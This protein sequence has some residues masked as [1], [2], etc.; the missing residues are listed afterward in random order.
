MPGE[1]GSTGYT[2]PIG[3][4]GPGGGGS[5]ITG[6]GIGNVVVYDTTSQTS[7][8]SEVVQIDNNAVLPTQDN[9]YSLGNTG[10]RWKEI[11]MGP[12]T[13]FIAGPS[14][15]TGATLGANNQ[16]IAY[17]ESGF[18]TPFINIGPA[19]LTPQASG[20]WELYAQGSATGPNYTLVAQQ[21]DAITGEL[22]GPI[23]DLLHR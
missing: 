22:T 14:G 18:A 13:L 19:E 16:G 2:G 15:S 4:T 7:A 21:V 9:I 5:S 17:T 12:G 8:Y 10:F 6:T 1:P 3:P 11:F 20:G 23:Y